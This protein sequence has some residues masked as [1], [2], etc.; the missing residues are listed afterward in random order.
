MNVRIQTTGMGPSDV[1][2]CSPPAE[3]AQDATTAIEALEKGLK[4]MQDLC[5]VV[6]DKFWQARGEFMDRMEA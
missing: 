5:D 3:S 4:D 1:Q 2:I 6:A